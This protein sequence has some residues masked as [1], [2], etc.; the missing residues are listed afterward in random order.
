MSCSLLK[1]SFFGGTMGK[2]EAVFPNQHGAALAQ[3]GVLPFTLGLRSRL[4]RGTSYVLSGKAPRLPHH[5]TW[6]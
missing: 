2:R 4:R 6:V 3:I 5:G 1:F